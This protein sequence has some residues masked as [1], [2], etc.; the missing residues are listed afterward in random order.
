MFATDCSRLENRGRW[1]GIV[2]RSGYLGETSALSRDWNTVLLGG[3]G[4]LQWFG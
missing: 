4:V 1:A 2:G 3:N